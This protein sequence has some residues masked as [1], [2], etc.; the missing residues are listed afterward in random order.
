MQVRSLRNENV[1]LEEKV[2]EFDRVSL[3]LKKASAAVED[4]KAQISTKT[5]LER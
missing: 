5:N 3:E 1:R 2:E 4:L